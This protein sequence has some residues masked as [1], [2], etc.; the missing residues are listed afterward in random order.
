MAIISECLRH[1][2]AALK[3]ASNEG[4]SLVD[5]Q[6]QQQLVFPRLF[7]YVM[8]DPESKDVNAIKGGNTL[9]PCEHCMVTSQQLGDIT[10]PRFP[11]R[12]EK[13]QVCAMP[14]PSLPCLGPSMHRLWPDTPVL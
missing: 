7:S 4:L 3:K 10:G 1:L 2:L 5:P 8:D 9:H 11:H 6:G 13:H 12:T 14:Y